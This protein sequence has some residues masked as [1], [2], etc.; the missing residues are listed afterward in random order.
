MGGDKR[1]FRFLG[2]EEYA[3]LSAEQ[4]TLYLRAA[5]EALEWRQEQLRKLVQELIN[6][7]RPKQS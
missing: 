4:R 2:D 3:R 6:E 7:N 5:A 1:Q